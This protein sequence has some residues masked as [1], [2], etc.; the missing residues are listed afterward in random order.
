M[1]QAFPQN[2]DFG[3]YRAYAL[4]RDVLSTGT[5][6][7]VESVLLSRSDATAGW[8]TWIISQGA[9]SHWRQVW[10]TGRQ[11][12]ACRTKSASPGSTLSRRCTSMHRTNASIFQEWCFNAHIFFGALAMLPTSLTS[13]FPTDWCCLLLEELMVLA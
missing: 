4:P 2:L 1:T 11:H 7:L 8:G 5:E 9:A 13:Y 6:G 10:L 3:D 12:P